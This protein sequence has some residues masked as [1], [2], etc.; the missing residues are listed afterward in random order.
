MAIHLNGT[1]TL[2]ILTAIKNTFSTGGK[3]KIPNLSSWLFIYSFGFQLL[4]LV[5][6]QWWPLG[7]GHGIRLS[8]PSGEIL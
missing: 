1:K 7:Y 3:R 8:T 5:I 6:F 2:T 4:L